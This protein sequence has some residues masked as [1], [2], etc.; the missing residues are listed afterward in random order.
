MK[1]EIHAV[2]LWS[3]ALPQRE[4]ILADLAEH[5]ELVA[6]YRVEWPPER[7][8]HNLVRLYGFKPKQAA[9]K[10]DDSGR[11]P[12]LLLVVRDPAPHYESRPRSWGSSPANTKLYDA[13]QRYRIWTDGD[14]RVHT[15]IDEEEA[16]RDLFLL[17]SRR[18]SELA[19]APA[20]PWSAEPELLEAEIV[21]A[22]G[23]AST[24]QLLA[25]L[26]VVCGYE[27][28]TEEPLRL[29]VTD[30]ARAKQLVGPDAPVELHGEGDRHFVGLARKVRRRLRR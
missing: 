26:D 4:R 12:F 24:E 16:E 17:L 6:A 8:A 19:D 3:N 10:A 29:R 11:D 5:V 2:V 22:D 27:V 20:I 28:L 30:L 25:A 14:F 13:K 18:S 9:V 15:T 21:G 7:F 23:W 1:P